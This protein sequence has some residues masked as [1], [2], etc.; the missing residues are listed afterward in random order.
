MFS[1]N[2]SKG[3]VIFTLDPGFLPLKRHP[4]APGTEWEGA[5]GRLLFFTVNFLEPQR[6]LLIDHSDLLLDS[7]RRVR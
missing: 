5:G 4:I 1:S 7:V 2:M 6:T 3:N